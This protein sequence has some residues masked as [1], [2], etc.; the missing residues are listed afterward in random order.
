MGRGDVTEGTFQELAR[1][2]NPGAG[3]TLDGSV[4]GTGRRG[5]RGALAG[6]S[7]SLQLPPT[8]FLR[9]SNG[10]Y[11]GFLFLGR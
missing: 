8:R 1:G 7:E 4:T 5:P 3:G 10:V 2:R 9:G 6:P 11:T